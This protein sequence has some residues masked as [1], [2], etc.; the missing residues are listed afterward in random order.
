VTSFEDSN[1]P[2]EITQKAL[3]AWKNNCISTYNL[4]KG[5]SFQAEF[6]EVVMNT[7]VSRSHFQRGSEV[8]D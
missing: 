6:P 8:E 3:S 7:T 4:L 2:T 1:T 5:V